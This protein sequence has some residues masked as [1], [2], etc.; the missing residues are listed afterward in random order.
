MA[1]RT[2]PIERAARMLDL[3]PFIS[4]HQGIPIRELAESFNISVEELASD[5]NALWMCGDSRF[6]LIDLEFESGYVSIRNADTLNRVRSLNQQELISLAIGLDMIEKQIGDTRVDL[7]AVISNLKR[8]LTPHFL[9]IVDA[10]PRKS[11]LIF[12]TLNSALASRQRVSIEYFSAS[13]DRISE[14]IISPLNITQENGYEFVIAFC[15][16]AQSQRTFRIDR[17]SKAEI[18]GSDTPS[19]SVEQT[20]TGPSMISAKAHS[21]ARRI[22]ET[23]GISH[24]SSQAEMQIPIYNPQWMIRT[25]LS[26][27]GSLEVTSPHQIRAAVLTRANEALALYG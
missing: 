5:L 24:S 18:V 4:S 21:N 19:L 13:E 12:S 6:D 10:S 14:R 11:E 20:K 16:L 27:A 2:T 1:K 8:K 23:F 15:Q 3:V 22:H 26:L 25:T 7:V 9:H 17:I